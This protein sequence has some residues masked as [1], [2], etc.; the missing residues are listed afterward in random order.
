MV[1]VCCNQNLPRLVYK[2]GPFC[3]DVAISPLGFRHDKRTGQFPGK[4]FSLRISLPICPLIV[5]AFPF[6]LLFEDTIPKQETNDSS[7]HHR[8][9]P[10]NVLSEPLINLSG[11]AQF[12]RRMSSAQDAAGSANAR[13][14]YG[15]RM[16]LIFTVDL[17]LWTR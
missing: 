4:T 9:H 10:V 11:T 13:V 15:R 12:P 7:S 3:V 1:V 2:S 6:V 16:T 17:V 8:P 5:S 14:K